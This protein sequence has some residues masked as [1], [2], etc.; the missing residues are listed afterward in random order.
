MAQ[1]QEGYFEAQKNYF[2]TIKQN[3]L[4][5]SEVSAHN[6]KLAN[7]SFIKIIK[8][9]PYKVHTDSFKRVLDMEVCNDTSYQ[10][11]NALY[12]LDRSIYNKYISGAFNHCGVDN[13]LLTVLKGQDIE[14]ALTLIDGYK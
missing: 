3:Q 5:Q 4:R 10:T 1:F 13:E 14:N 2:D 9:V 6:R 8:G 7:T 12:N 11:R